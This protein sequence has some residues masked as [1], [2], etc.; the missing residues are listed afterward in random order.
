[1]L[2]LRGYLENDQDVLKLGNA[3]PPCFISLDMAQCLEHSVENRLRFSCVSEEGLQF[4]RL[5]LSHETSGGS[6]DTYLDSCISFSLGRP[7]ESG[8]FDR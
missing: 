6:P 1:V 4:R 7:G 3:C 5:G 8:L 2:A